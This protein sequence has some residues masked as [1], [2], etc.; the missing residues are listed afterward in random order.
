MA[1]FGEKLEPAEV[2]S[3]FAEADTNKDGH[4]SY[5]EFVAMMRK[6]EPEAAAPVKPIARKP[7]S[8]KQLEEFKVAFKLFGKDGT[9][10][11]DELAL[12]MAK[13]GENLEATEL[14]VM[15][16]EADTDKD[17]RISYEEFVAMMKKGVPGAVVPVRPPV[18]KKTLTEEQLAEFREAFKLFDKDG[19]QTITAKEL[20]E[21]LRSLD[22]APTEAEL[23]DMINEVDADGNGTIDFEEFVELMQRHT[24]DEGDEFRE[25]FR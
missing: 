3:M 16:A 8:E 12:A 13:F 20:G 4:I 5:D 18:S 22:Q 2:K 1:E 10:T 19:D 7:L 14:K 21:V 6:G 15:F 23:L 11:E 24:S 25:A 9:I 17:G